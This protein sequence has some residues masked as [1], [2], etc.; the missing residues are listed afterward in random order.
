MAKDFGLVSYGRN[1]I[2]QYNTYN[3]FN[4]R[5]IYCG[6]EL[7]STILFAGDN[8]LL[9]FKNGKFTEIDLEGVPKTFIINEIIS[10][11]DSIYAIINSSSIWKYAGGKWE[12]SNF[13]SSK[14]TL[15]HLLSDDKNNLWAG[16]TTGLFK[17]ID[18]EA[19]PFLKGGLSSQNIIYTIVESNDSSLW[20]GTDKGL[21]NIKND[22]VVKTLNKED[23]LISNIVYA[24]KIQGDKIFIGTRLGLSIHTNNIFRSYTTNEGFQTITFYLKTWK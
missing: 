11:T 15:N 2:K 18:N 4:G 12:K 10:T 7:D 13:F 17:I 14:L 5:N 20:V 22:S 8:I 23:G 21:L 6:I 24:L 3:V 16:T 1:N 9:E 19:R